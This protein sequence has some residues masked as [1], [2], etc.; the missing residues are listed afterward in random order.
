MRIDVPRD[1]KCKKPK[2][3][4]ENVPNCLREGLK[5]F[6]YVFNLPSDGEVSVHF[7]LF[8]GED[9]EKEPAAYLVVCKCGSYPAVTD[10]ECRSIV[11]K[12]TGGTS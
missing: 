4:K 3:E 2:L 11:R 6:I 1:K 7:E 9:C 10:D 5:L 8:P 12:D